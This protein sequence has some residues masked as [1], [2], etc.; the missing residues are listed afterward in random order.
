MVVIGGDQGAGTNATTTVESASLNLFGE[1]GTW[2]AQ[3]NAL[4]E[5][6]AFAGYDR[7]GSFVYLAGGQS[8]TSTTTAQ[9]TVLRATILNPLNAPTMDVDIDILDQQTTNFTAG[10]WFYRVS[11][12][13]DS[14]YAR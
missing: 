13:F 8:G 7:I 6:R 10:V 14:L 3:R 11:A 5:A 12:I 4:P 9:N 1:V 2:S